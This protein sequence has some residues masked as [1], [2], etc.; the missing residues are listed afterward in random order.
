M[1]RAGLAVLVL[2]AGCSRNPATGRVQFGLPSNDEEIAI[3]REGDGKVREA[4]GLYDEVPAATAMVEGIG[5][6]IAKASERPDL[7]WKFQILDEPAVNAFALPGG[8]VYVTRGLL[9][10]LDSDDELAAVLA[11]ETGHV[12]A[13]HGVVHM[14]KTASARRSVGLFRVIDPG[15]RHVGGLAARA[16]GLSLLRYSREDEHEADDLSVRY[17]RRGGWDPAAVVRVFGILSRLQAGAAKPPPWLSTH[18]DPAERR[19]RTAHALGIPQEQGS[20]P[21]EGYLRAIAGLAF[22]DDPRDGFLAGTTFV[23][24]RRGFQIDLPSGWKTLHDK[25]SVV[26]VSPDDRAVFVLLET[27][28][29]TPDEALK[30]FFADGGMSPGQRWDGAVGGF[31]VASS[32][33]AMAD[34]AGRKLVG[35]VAFVAFDG[36][37]LA[38]VTIGPE[39]G[40]SA[41]ADVLARTFASFAKVDE[42]VRNVEPMRVRLLVLDKAATITELAK[43]GPVDA[44]T[45]AL[46]NQVGAEEPLAKGRAVKIVSPAALGNP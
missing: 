8:W 21:E 10:H 22:G 44:A 7:P 25:A 31:P 15:L 45:L 23:Q 2:V 14:R 38:L 3:G 16:A 43:G 40:W 20:V 4:L 35:L 42:Q 30:A 28:N 18:P 13:R 33:F 29:K 27:E 37:V 26:A 24:P 5:Q 36:R 34:E 11:H 17:I 6:R 12:T 19:G 39:E 41:R 1:S 9:A 46:V 32:A